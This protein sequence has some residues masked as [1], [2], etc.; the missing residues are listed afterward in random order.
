MSDIPPLPSSGLAEEM[1]P[2][3][4]SRLRLP[5]ATDPTGVVPPR[6]PTGMPPARPPILELADKLQASAPR[7]EASAPKL[8]QAV[9]FSLDKEEYAAR[10]DSVLE[11]LRVAPIARVPAAPPHVRGVMNLRGRLL[12]VVELRTLLGLGPLAIDDESRV[13]K[14]TVLGRLVGLLVDRVS[15]VMSLS[16]DAFEPPPRELGDRADFLAGVTLKGDGV[17]L[18]LDLERTLS[19]PRWGG[20]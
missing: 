4:R 12:P 6:A 20:K 8:I 9:L 3:L 15:Y 11:I 5:E 13:I 16:E 17:V 18:M 10:I 2:L 19:P 1:I 7:V 14:A